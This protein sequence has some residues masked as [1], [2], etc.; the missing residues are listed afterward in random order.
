MYSARYRVLAVPVLCG[1]TG[2]AASNFRS[3]RW[4]R[5]AVAA[6]ALLPAP[7][8]LANEA[9]GFGRLDFMREDFAKLLVDTHLEAGRTRRDEGN[10]IA[11]E[12]HF[13]RAAEVD[14]ERPEAHRELAALHLESGALAEAR[15]AA[16]GA[17]RRNAEDEAAHR[18]LYDAQVR[19][20]DYRS[21]LVTL[22]SLAKLAPEDASTHIALA[23]LYAA[24]PD[25]T[26]RNRHKALFHAREAR[27]I[28]G[29]EAPDILMARALA[30]A[31]RGNFD[32][33]TAAARRGVAMAGEQGNPTER[34]DFESLLAHLAERRA[35][36]TRPRLFQTR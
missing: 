14:P 32:A 35:I 11:A 3:A 1:L 30:E 18:L 21:A 24:C 29:G 19:S 26:L 23:W 16:L 9:T 27:R 25:F 15:T 5:T 6:L 33:A 22:H 13:R 36:A 10:P 34:R 12:S 31:S 20:E 2:F 4:P 17:L 28:R 8:L 7:L